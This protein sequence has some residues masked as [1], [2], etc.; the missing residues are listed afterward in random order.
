GIWGALATGIFTKTSINSVARWDGLIYGDYHLMVAQI[1][2]VAITIGIAVVG[3]MLCA[4]AVKIFIPLRVSDEDEKVG[5]D[6]SQHGEK[7]YPAF[8]GLD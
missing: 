4:F 8:N 7:A 2:S 1:I 3:T 6:V 5:L